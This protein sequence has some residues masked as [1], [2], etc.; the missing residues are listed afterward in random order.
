MNRIEENDV[1][2]SFSGEKRAYVSRLNELLLSRGVRVFYDENIWGNSVSLVE[3]AY[4]DDAARFVVVFR[5]LNYRTNRWPRHEWDIIRKRSNS[6]RTLLAFF[7]GD[8]NQAE[9]FYS[10][11]ISP[12]KMETHVKEVIAAIDGVFGG[13]FYPT[14]NSGILR[15]RDKFL[16]FFLSAM[17][18]YQDF[19]DK[20]AEF[21]KDLKNEDPEISN[22][23]PLKY[24]IE[25]FSENADYLDKI[26]INIRERAP[27]EFV[28][29]LI[30]ILIKD[31]PELSKIFRVSLSLEFNSR[32][33]SGGSTFITKTE[34]EDKRTGVD[35]ISRYVMVIAK[36]SGHLTAK[37]CKAYLHKI[38][39]FHSGA[40]IEIYNETQRLAWSVTGIDPPVD[41]LPGE[42]RIFDV[43]YTE[44]HKGSIVPQT[45]VGSRPLTWRS[46]F[47]DKTSY[48]F[49]VYVT[50]DNADPAHM[51]IEV[52]WRGNWDDFV[53]RKPDEN[54]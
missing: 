31:R 39:K 41:I 15:D 11:A 37:N 34:S 47:L 22:D 23:N 46:A 28:E 35:Y 14:L 12:I 42:D 43:F 38:E 25:L 27:E 44:S 50:C 21:I 5:S 45:A 3:S 10:Q 30:D 4:C 1:A 16:D 52:E 49:H 51:E 33:S 53:C 26:R 54:S 17:R 20:F 7:D 40:Y 6:E 32:D 24:Y 18:K 36:N 2:L 9:T 29:L 48:R 13:Y 19:D 8:E